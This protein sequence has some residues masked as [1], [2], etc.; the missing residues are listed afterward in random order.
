ML[1]GYAQNYYFHL[2]E[3]I[4]CLVVMVE[5]MLTSCRPPQ[6]QCALMDY[7]NGVREV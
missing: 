3:Y 1:F 5:R 6:E 2:R 7:E 4:C